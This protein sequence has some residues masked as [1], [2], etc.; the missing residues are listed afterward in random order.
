M[1]AGQSGRQA[2]RDI[3][4]EDAQNVVPPVAQLFQNFFDA[5]GRRPAELMHEHNPSTL[6][7]RM[8]ASG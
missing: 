8:A 1:Q 3:V 2:H 4:E 5:L 7:A 6:S